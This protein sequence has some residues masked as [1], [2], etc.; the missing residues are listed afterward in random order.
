MN[1]RV[2][3]SV[4]MIHRNETFCQF[5]FYWHKYCQLSGGMKRN[6]KDNEV[7]IMNFSGIYSSEKFIND[8]RFKVLDCTHLYGTD[9]YCDP[10]AADKIKR[11]LKPLSYKG[12]HFIDSGDYH[13]ISKFWTDKINEPFNLL[14]FDHHT[15]MQEPAFC[16]ILSCGDWVKE[17]LDTN[18][19]LKKVI[20]V[21]PPETMKKTLPQEYRDR[22]EFHSESEL[23]REEGWRCYL[24]KHTDVPLYISIDKDILMKKSCPTNWDQGQVS[25]TLLDEI[26][27]AVIEKEHVIGIDICG[28]CSPSLD[29]VEKEQ[30]TAIN[31]NVNINLLRTIIS[32][33]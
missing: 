2:T 6:I 21:G 8:K 33:N 32:T 7:V 12:I 10:E 1:A 14:V 16:S 27:S 25:L 22:V 3:E 26:L 4:R 9:C 13:Y 11:L 23:I 18:I 29:F 31:D 28:E 19:H 5:R 24:S 15:D 17:V 30:M 20:L